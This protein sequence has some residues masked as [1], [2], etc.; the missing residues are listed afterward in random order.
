[1]KTVRLLEAGLSKLVKK[2]MEQEGYQITDA[3]RE[4]RE[5]YA[6]MPP[7]EILKLARPGSVNYGKTP[8]ELRQRK[9]GLFGGGVDG[10]DPDKLAES[11]KVE[12][13]DFQELF[14]GL[15]RLAQRDLSTHL[16]YFRGVVEK[17]D[18]P[19]EI[20]LQP[21]RQTPID[22]SP[23]ALANTLSVDDI[24]FKKLF[25]GLAYLSQR[26]RQAYAKYFRHAVPK[27]EAKNIR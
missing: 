18:G 13:I 14:I 3:D 10:P 4:R 27:W 6:N 22:S 8:E 12:D 11:L 5:K 9:G 17:W 24:N 21:N 15:A 7:E 26:D 2:I 19:K 23:E 20:M 16:K 25:R 1:M